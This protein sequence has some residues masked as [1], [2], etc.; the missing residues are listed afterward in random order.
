M[1][2]NRTVRLMGARRADIPQRRRRQV[3]GVQKTLLRAPPSL[4]EPRAVAQNKLCFS[5]SSSCHTRALRLS[6]SSKPFSGLRS[7]YA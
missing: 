6:Q 2:D 4:R 7:F 5:F 3:S 1:D